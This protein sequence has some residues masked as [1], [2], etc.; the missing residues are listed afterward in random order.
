[1][2]KIISFFLVSISTLALAV[3]DP[4]QYKELV[5]RKVCPVKVAPNASGRIVADFGRDAVGWLEL[6]GPES[7]PYEIAIGELVNRSGEVTNKYPKSSIRCQIVSGVK[8][9]GRYRVPMP[10]DGLN[11][12]GY[13]PKA[14]AICLPERFGVVFPFRYAEILRGPQM[15]LRQ[16][17]VNYPIDMEKSAF[18][19]DSADLVRV[20]EFCKYSILA[21]SFCGIYVDG[22]RER[23]PYEADA[24]INQLG[25][26]AIDDDCSLARKSHEWLMEH[27]TWPTEW[28]QHSIMMAW[29]DWMWTGDTRSIAKYYDKLANEKLMVKFA[30]SPD[31]LLETGGERGMGARPGAS[32]IVDWPSGER[33]GFVFKPVN[34]VVNAFFYRNLREMS[35]IAAALG[36]AD[37][38]AKFSARAERTRD[39]FQAAFYRPGLHL[40]ADGEGTDHCSLHANAAALAF[41]LV[42]KDRVPAV[43]S[44]LERKGMPCSVY[45]AQYL[46]EAFF[47]AGRADI[48]IGL[49]T[50]HGDRSWMGM[51]DF[52]STISMEAW[53]L[54]AKPNLDL[55][56]AWGAAPL[57]IIS[58][59]VVG[60][61][62]LEP[63]F[64]KIAIRPQIGGL[65][66]V[67]ATVPTAA[68]PVTLKI[69]SECLKFTAPSP[70]E[71]TFGGKT[72]SFPAGVH[73]LSPARPL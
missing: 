72:R 60:V 21:T 16:I 68:G 63:G 65:K 33:D 32:D 41:G 28:R 38:A 45:F 69:S 57:N 37:H 35:D 3:P 49:M 24:Y 73:E 8:P 7:G 54:A 27:P 51:M 14:P 13:D 58:R 1:M 25:H 20:Y 50:S 6:D 71:V 59:Y 42:P 52:G 10:P 39:A 4:Y 70:S 12:K 34:A 5:V 61:T 46:L 2:K 30:R 15:T 29:A 26:Y 43:V 55:N 17:A 9:A 64:R 66:R 47:A 22:D 53:N 44:F 36:K 19:C 23:T 48:A 31:G 62:P 11:L 67:S 18:D 40:Y 56:H